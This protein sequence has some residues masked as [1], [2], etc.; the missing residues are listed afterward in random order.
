MNESWAIVYVDQ[1]GARAESGGGEWNIFDALEYFNDQDEWTTIMEEG[2]G[3]NLLLEDSYNNPVQLKFTGVSIVT[4]PGCWENPSESWIEF[5]GWELIEEEVTMPFFDLF[6]IIKEMGR[7]LLR[8]IV[9]VPDWL[10]ENPGW[11]IAILVGLA[12]L[13]LLYG[14]VREGC[15]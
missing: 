8:V 5:E 12:F 2:E 14:R 11:T 3:L 10:I 13:V 4:T 7:E 9:K 6:G 15:W 1:G